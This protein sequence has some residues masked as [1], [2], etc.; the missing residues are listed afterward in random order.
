MKSHAARSA[1]IFERRY[2]SN[3]G[4]AGS[5]QIVSSLIRVGRHHDAL[6]AGAARCAQDAQ[7]AVAGRRIHG[8][9]VVVRGAT[10]R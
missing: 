4:S 9:W 3:C 10:E 8:V 7:R 6:H 5:A 2:A 1:R